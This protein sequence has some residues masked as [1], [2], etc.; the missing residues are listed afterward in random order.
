MAC[1]RWGGETAGPVICAGSTCWIS[2]GIASDAKAMPRGRAL[3]P[4]NTLGQRAAAS[5]QHLACA[6]RDLDVKAIR[7]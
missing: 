3:G 2:T 1:R 4:G 6:F 7:N 5:N